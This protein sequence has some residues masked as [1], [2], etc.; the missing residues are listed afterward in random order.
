MIRR[1]ISR[2]DLVNEPHL[3]WNSF[4][5]VIATE[6]FEDLC[7]TQRLAQ[8]VFLYDAE[9]NNGG[10]LQYFLNS[11]GERACETLRVLLEQG[12]RHQHSIL[13]AALEIADSV[14]LS[15]IDSLEDYIAEAAEERFGQLD[16][17]YYGHQSEVDTFLERYLDDHFN[18]FIELT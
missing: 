17:R 5:D 10:H 6:A 16:L 18:D 8:L 9:V 2:Q 13:E 7:D 14:S 11:A 3:A 15:E 4:I 1:Q 12:L